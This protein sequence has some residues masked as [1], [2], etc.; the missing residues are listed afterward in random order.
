MEHTDPTGWFCGERSRG[1]KRHHLKIEPDE[2]AKSKAIRSP[3]FRWGLSD[4]TE[5]ESLEEFSLSRWR[6][7]TEPQEW[8]Q[9]QP[10]RCI[11]DS[12]ARGSIQTAISTIA[13]AMV[14]SSMR[15]QSV[16][17]TGSP[18]RAKAAMIQ[19]VTPTT[20]AA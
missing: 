11:H 1:H 18:T 19:M 8:T 15:F 10:R 16:S 2:T 17:I 9:H 5:A 7:L 13:E 14:V 12:L 3:A 4:S 6:G 20:A